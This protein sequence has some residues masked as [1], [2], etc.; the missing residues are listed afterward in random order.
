MRARSTAGAGGVGG[1][2]L[3]P[4]AAAPA[5]VPRTAAVPPLRPAC[6]PGDRRPGRARHDRRRLHLRMP[7]PAIAP[8]LMHP[9]ACMPRPAIAPLSPT[10][11]LPAIA[12]HPSPALP[13]WRRPA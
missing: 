7:R 10:A 1:R 9:C 4:G 5:P 12:P 3:G 11:S 13:R 6:P 8:A 2:A